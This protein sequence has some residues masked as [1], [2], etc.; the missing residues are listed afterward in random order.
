MK[1]KILATSIVAILSTSPVLA[2]KISGGPRANF[3][4]GTLVV[5]CVKILH[6]DNK[7][8][9]G[10]F[11]D[12]VLKQQGDSLSYEVVFGE[13]EDDAVCLPSIE[14]M[15]LSDSDTEDSQGSLEDFLS[16]PEDQPGDRPGDQPGDRPGD[17]PGDKPG[18]KPGDRPGDKPG[19]RPGDQPTR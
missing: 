6:S 9:E 16:N 13:L 8:L 1:M 15:L 4:K 2:D 12:V 5:P 10:H 18:D 17:Q 14:A 11:F 3:A 19:D 7:D